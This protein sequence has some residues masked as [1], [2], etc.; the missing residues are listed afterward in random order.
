MVGDPESEIVLHAKGAHFGDRPIL[1]PRITR[2]R[3]LGVSRLVNEAKDSA[4][5]PVER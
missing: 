5:K 1:G 4:G 3:L 2:V